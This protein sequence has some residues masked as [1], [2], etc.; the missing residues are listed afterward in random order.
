[1]ENRIV[2]NCSECVNMRGSVALYFIQEMTNT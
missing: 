1:M 2:E